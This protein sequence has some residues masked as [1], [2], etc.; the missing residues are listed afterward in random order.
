MKE[1]IKIAVFVETILD[2]FIDVKMGLYSDIV[3]YQ[4][5]NDAGSYLKKR[6]RKFE[7]MLDF[8]LNIQKKDL[9]KIKKSYIKKLKEVKNYF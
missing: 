7:E 2:Y 8:T 3:W 6:N 4:L 9:A 5:L 1:I